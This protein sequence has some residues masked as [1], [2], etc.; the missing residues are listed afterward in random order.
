MKTLNFLS[1]ESI[2]CIL[3]SLFNPNSL[4][5]FSTD[6][7]STFTSTF[8]VSKISS[9]PSN[10]I[11]DKFLFKVNLD[12]KSNSLNHSLFSKF[13]F[14]ELPFKDISIPAFES[15]SKNSFD[16]CISFSL[17][18]SIESYTS[19]NS[20]YFL[21]GILLKL[22]SRKESFKFV[23]K[24]AP[25]VFNCFKLNSSKA[26]FEFPSNKSFT[27]LEKDEIFI[28]FNFKS[29]LLSKTSKFAISNFESIT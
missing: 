13:K 26:I 14:F 3:L 11:D 22:I 25:K 4:V 15:A 2:S 16:F 29:A 12:L 8:I 24:L 20:S 1:S 5:A 10:F 19:I 28:F 17:S 23:C 18:C 21:N 6:S 9:I 7:L 27:I